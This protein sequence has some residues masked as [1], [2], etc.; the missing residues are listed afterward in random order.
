M[1][2]QWV[3]HASILGWS[4]HPRVERYRHFTS[5]ISTNLWKSY[6]H[7]CGSEIEFWPWP[8]GLQ[9]RAVGF[10][11]TLSNLQ[12]YESMTR[13]SHKLING[14]KDLSHSSQR[15]S[16]AVSP[17]LTFG[18]GEGERDKTRLDRL[19][20]DDVLMDGLE[21]P[22][23]CRLYSLTSSSNWA[24]LSFES[25][26]MSCSASYLSSRGILGGGGGGCRCESR[27]RRRFLDSWSN[28]SCSRSLSDI[29]RLIMTGEGDLE[30]LAKMWG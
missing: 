6:P 1:T 2:S 25:P 13:Y 3:T 15:L 11:M 27:L 8:Y 20:R 5:R 30:L 9:E 7:P 28:I 22:L 14:P 12:W 24:R 21:S 16:I 10:A 18:C 17:S 29:C 19:S 23:I 26:G 4:R